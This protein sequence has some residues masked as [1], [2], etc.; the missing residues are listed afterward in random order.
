VAGWADFNPV[1]NAARDALQQAAKV[2]IPEATFVLWVVGAYLLVLVPLNW[3]FFRLIGRVEWAWVAAPVIAVVCTAV[4]IR[5]AR[6]DIGFERSANEVAVVELQGGHSRAHVTRF[7]ALYTALYTDYTISSDDPGAQI[8]PFPTV[9]KPGDFQHKLGDE[10]TR[11][12]YRHATEATA[13]EG[14]V[15]PSNSTKFLHSEHLLDLGGPVHLME[16]S[17]GGFSIQNRTDYT[18][19]GAGVLWKKV[20]PNGGLELAWLDDLAPGVTAGLRFVRP[21]ESEVRILWADQR[22]RSPLTMD[23]G[24][25]M[26]DGPLRGG[27]LN[28]N[29]MLNVAQQTELLPGEMR[30]VAWLDEPLPGQQIEPAARRTQQAAVVI[31]HLRFAPGPDPRPDV[32]PRLAVDPKAPRVLT[33]AETKEEGK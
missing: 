30:L 24:G 1:A 25:T 18:L 9:S 7:T 6:L 11:L 5:L 15:V 8:L 32:V 23:P 22:S 31:A 10:I 21:A 12:R 29:A 20:T 3:V 17:D 16:S 2:E 27:Q 4:V 13:L 26:V 19:R 14:F 28:L 33:P